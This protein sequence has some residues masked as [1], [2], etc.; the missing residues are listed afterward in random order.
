MENT[1]SQSKNKQIALN[2]KVPAFTCR[3][4]PEQKIKLSDFERPKAGHL[5]LSQ[6]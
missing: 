6:K 4:T 5:F 1:K 3:G 2:K